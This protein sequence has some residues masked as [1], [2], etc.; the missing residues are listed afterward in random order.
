MLGVMKVL[1]RVLV[2]GRI[3]AAHMAAF[4]AQA[5]MN[6]GVAHL[7]AF[8]AA[9]AA[10][11]DVANLI[12]VSAGLCHRLSSSREI[13]V[14]LQ[15]RLPTWRKDSELLA[16]LPGVVCGIGNRSSQLIFASTLR[17]GEYSFWLPAPES[18][19]RRTA[20]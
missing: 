6:P 5:E 12:E 14:L 2:L 4:Q 19:G 20:G 11:G 1:G 15:L 8:L 10:G 16:L 9:F 18:N 13:S 3:A 17:C 7:Q